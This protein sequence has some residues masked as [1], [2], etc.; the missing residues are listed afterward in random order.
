MQ[1]IARASH[2]CRAPDVPRERLPAT[3]PRPSRRSPAGP[4]TGER[5]GLRVRSGV[6]RP[7]SSTDH[8][9]SVRPPSPLQDDEEIQVRARRGFASDN[10]PERDNPDEGVAPSLEDPTDKLGGQGEIARHARGPLRRRRCRVLQGFHAQRIERDALGSRPLAQ[11]P[12]QTGRDLTNSMVL[13][14]LSVLQSPS[15]GLKI[16]T[17]RWRRRRQAGTWN[18]LRCPSC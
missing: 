7:S 3:V 13:P 10:R 15:L 4:R 16:S 11:A 18:W 2:P 17:G 9:G 12:V 5:R 8:R 14:L 6:R 1:G